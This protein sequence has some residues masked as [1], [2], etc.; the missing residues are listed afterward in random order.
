MSRARILLVEDEMAVRL[1]MG[2]FLRDRYDVVEVGDGREAVDRLLDEEFD[3]VVSDVR[4][5]GMDGLELLRWVKENR[6]ELDVI[7]VTSDTSKSTAEEAVRSGAYDFIG[8]PISRDELLNR[9][10]RALEA[11]FLRIRNRQLAGALE[12]ECAFGS[13]IGESPQMKS[14]FRTMEKVLGNDATVLVLGETGTGKE[15]VAKAIHFNGTRKNGPYVAVN[16]GAISET[17]LESELFGHEKGAFTGAVSAKKGLFE[18][19]DGGTIFLDEISEMP[20]ELQSKLLRVLQER[21]VMRVGSVKPRKIDVRVIAASNRD[22]AH[23][24]KE[25]RFRADLYYR[26]NVVP[27]HLP[28]LRE[29]KGDVGL[30]ARYFLEKISA[31]MGVGKRRLTP[32][33]LRLLDSYSWP[34]NVRELQNVMER[35]VSLWEG[36]VIT[37]DAFSFL[38]EEA[39]I[40]G[41]TIGGEE[42]PSP[43]GGKNATGDELIFPETREGLTTLAELERRYI[44]HVLD[45]CS[46]NKTEAA[47]RLGIDYTTLLRKLKRYEEAGNA[48]H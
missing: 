15:L 36:E 37:A 43:R 13:M 8:K 9:V 28:P 44:Y 31:R 19:A 3:L 25:G 29:R 48:V 26:L 6:P 17:L 10:S 30:L 18:E 39:S 42:A 27:I 22:L 35:V 24:V 1:Y 46:G 40:L 41:E 14:V 33:A 47:K 2:E 32:D 45:V 38:Y 5:P 11:R 7:I 12:K 34:G 21:E 20:K 4:M 16:C 23:E